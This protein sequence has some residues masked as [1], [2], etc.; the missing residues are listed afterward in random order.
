MGGTRHDRQ[1]R[2]LGHASLDLGRQ[3]LGVG[4]AAPGAAALEGGHTTL[5]D[6]QIGVAEVA[7]VQM[8]GRAQV[9]VLEVSD[10]TGGGVTP[11]VG[12]GRFLRDGTNVPVGSGV[13]KGIGVVRLSGV[14]Y[15]ACTRRSA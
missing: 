4:M 8:R 14:R 3:T 6:D 2:P 12:W 1:Q 15:Y 7:G 10:E 13:R 5:V 11:G 9:G